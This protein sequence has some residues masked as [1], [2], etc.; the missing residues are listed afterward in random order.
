MSNVTDIWTRAAIPA[1][2]PGIHQTDDTC[3]FVSIAGAINHLTGATITESHIM[4]IWEADGRPQPDFGLALKY[5]E[6]ELVAHS[7]GVERFH[8]REARLQTDD[9]IIDA[10]SNGCVVIPSFELASGNP[11]SLKRVALWHMLSIFSC[12]GGLFQVWDTNNKTGFISAAEIR[13]LFTGCALPI[14]NPPRGFLV[15]HDQREV[16]IVRLKKANDVMDVGTPLSV[17]LRS[18]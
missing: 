16:I 18:E 14:P 6:R 7:I 13:A 1:S 4:A 2:Y 11:T 5:L 12:G 15:P 8:D 17:Q 10:L 9:V 3:V